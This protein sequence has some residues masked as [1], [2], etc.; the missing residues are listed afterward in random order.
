MRDLVTW[1]FDTARG[2]LAVALP[3]R[4]RHVRAVADKAVRIRRLVEPDG[5]LLVA[6]ALL[7]DIG[8]APDVVR[9]G[10]HPVD[11]AR[12]LASIGAP[13]RLV[14]L[15]A[16]HTC[17]RVEAELRGMTAELAAF[18]DER[19][20]LRDALWY[21]DLT[22]GP[23]GESLTVTDRLAEVEQRYGPEDVVTR[24]IRT[25]RPELLRAVERTE[26]RLA[27]HGIHV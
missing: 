2:K 27:A 10:F 18:A 17:A 5:D 24:F 9:I 19:T 15:V 13:D 4:W 16:H 6:A 23:D 21:C 26:R 3:R 25:A 20:P 11:G 1:A 14:G 8:Y 7:H 22:I 12:Y